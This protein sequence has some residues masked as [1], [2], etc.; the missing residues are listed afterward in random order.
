MTQISYLQP[1]CHQ[2]ILIFLKG[3]KKILN[4]LKKK[5]D[6]FSQQLKINTG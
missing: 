4:F 6:Y 3:Q 5:V 1:Q 2:L